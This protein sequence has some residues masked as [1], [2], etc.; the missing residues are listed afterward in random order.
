MKKIVIKN[1]IINS[2][3]FDQNQ[4]NS[5]QIFLIDAELR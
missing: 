2:K 1:F 5:Y 3:I 4:E